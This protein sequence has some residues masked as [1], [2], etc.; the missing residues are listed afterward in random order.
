M[1]QMGFEFSLPTKVVFGPGSIGSLDAELPSSISRIFIVTDAVLVEKGL[2]EQVK[3]HLGNRSVEIF[4]AVEPN[5]SFETVDAGG[6][7]AR[8]HESQL[9][10]GL[11]G[12][13]P[14]DAAKGIAGLVANPALST[15]DLVSCGDL[16]WPAVP[17]VCIP[18]TSGT[19]SEVTPFAVFSNHAQRTK[20]GCSF[21]SFFPALALVDSEL[22]Y[23]MP[24]GTVIDTGLDVL[25]HAIEAFL[26][27][28]ASPLSDV[29]A[30]DAIARARTHLQQ[31]VAKDHA[32]MDEMALAATL[33][34]VAIAHASTIL[35]HVMGYPLT[36]EHDIPHGRASTLALL[37]FL[38]LL[39]ERLPES[40]KVQRLGSVF[41]GPGGMRQFVN[42]LG[43]QTSLGSYGIDRTEISGFVPKVIVKSDLEITPFPISE[44][45]ITTIYEKGFE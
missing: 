17:V 27:T 34:G 36:V 32:A 44:E 9:V 43:I 15:R 26:S 11:G 8:A 40:L 19:G 42:E 39:M 4:S 25:T 18:T 10:V 38:D 22:T 33:A 3:E 16:E 21:P 31:A 1:K 2:A 35:P 13:S 37:P 45:E 20:E 24:H 41:G 23:S 30:L 7:V 6:V 28:I 29:F 14:M 5:P 12:G